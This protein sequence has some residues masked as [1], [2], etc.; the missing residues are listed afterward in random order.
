MVTG[1]KKILVIYHSQG[2]TMELMARHFSTGA[3]REKE[4][5]TILKPAG[6]AGI[7]DLLGCDAIAI[8]SPEYFGTMAGMIKDFFD[9]TFGAAQEKT[10]GLPFV[11]F[12]CAGNDGRG[13]IMQIERIAAGYKWRKV[14]EHLRIVG[15]P[16]EKDLTDLE[17]LG[18]TL[19]AGLDFGIF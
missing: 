3:A 14:Q 9:R 19:A 17:E 6:D 10:I 4:V 15:R 1:K 13:A 7:D 8:G 5:T 16:G 12:V 11:I 2:G 18:Q